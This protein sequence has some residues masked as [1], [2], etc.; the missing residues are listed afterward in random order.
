MNFLNIAVIEVKMRLI[1][2]IMLATTG[3]EQDDDHHLNEIWTNAEEE[4]M[5]RT[6]AFI[7][8]CIL[9]LRENLNR[10]V[11]RGFKETI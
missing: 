5:E 7:K 8:L 2:K 1:K 6:P 3:I 9:L 11:E 4:R 10:E